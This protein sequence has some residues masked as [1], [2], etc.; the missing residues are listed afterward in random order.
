MRKPETRVVQLRRVRDHGRRSHVTLWWEVLGG[1][2]ATGKPLDRVMPDAMPPFEGGEG[3][4]LLE[5]VPKRA[6]YPWPSWRALRQVEPPAG[7]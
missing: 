6:G 4:F 3:W 5:R 2:L 1:A 7:R